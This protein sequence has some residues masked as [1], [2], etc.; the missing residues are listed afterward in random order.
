MCEIVGFVV[1]TTTT[2][3]YRGVGQPVDP[4]LSYVSRSLCEQS[5]LV[6]SAFWSVGF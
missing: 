6:S 3:I 2:I 4:F 5:P 1:I